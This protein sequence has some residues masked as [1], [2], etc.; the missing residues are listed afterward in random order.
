MHISKILMKHNIY[1]PGFS[2]GTNIIFMPQL[3]SN[4]NIDGNISRYI[5]VIDNKKFND[6]KKTYLF[7]KRN[8]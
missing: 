5:I 8:I 4:R 7:E 3:Y 1:L 6:I 2:R